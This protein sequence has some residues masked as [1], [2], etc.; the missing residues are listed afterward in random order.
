MKTLTLDNLSVRFGDVQ[1][2]ENV[3][4]QVNSGEVVMLAGPNGAGKSTLLQVLLGLV[5][6]DQGC[7]FVDGQ[8]TRS[9]YA[10]KENLGYLPESVAFS[11]SLTAQMVLNFF[12]RARGIG[13]ARV[14]EVLELV[15]LYESRKRPVGGFS[16]GMRQRLGLG[17]AVMSKPELL[18]LDEPTAGLDQQGLQVLYQILENWRSKGRMVV[19]TTHDIALMEQRVDRI[20][21]LKSGKVAAWE[22][23]DDL[24]K[25]YALPADVTLKL[26]NKFSPDRW[27][28]LLNGRVRLASSSGSVVQLKV[29]PAKLLELTKWVVKNEDEILELAVRDAQ[30]DRVYERVLELAK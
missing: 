19:L 7:L 20:C 21:I 23:P 27:T 3:S 6:Q 22:T 2:L 1:A 5:R 14:Q 18:V 15:D 24:R 12:A 16:K 30:F 29:H 17:I 26:A 11:S 10:F 28:G 25:Q 9:D 8:V 13:Q 4:L